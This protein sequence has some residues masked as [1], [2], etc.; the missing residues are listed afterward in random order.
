MIKLPKK[1]PKLS[2]ITSLKRPD[3]VGT[4][5]WCHSSERL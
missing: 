2:I 3:L 5:D 1:L 4:N